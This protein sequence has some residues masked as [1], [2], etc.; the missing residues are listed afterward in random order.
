MLNLF[1]IEK[2]LRRG[3]NPGLPGWNLTSLTTELCAL[4]IEHFLWCF[5]KDV[6]VHVYDVSNPDLENQIATVNSTLKTLDADL[7]QYI[8][9]VANKIDKL[10]DTS[11]VNYPN[12]LG[13]SAKR[14]TGNS[15]E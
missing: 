3:S 10:S 12:V 9:N 6:L 14:G 2:S 11:H 5:I 15:I 4:C 1:I 13:I 7:P 8:I